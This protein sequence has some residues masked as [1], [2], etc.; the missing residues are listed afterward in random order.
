M[1]GPFSD[2]LIGGQLLAVIYVNAVAEISL[3]PLSRT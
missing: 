2:R 1:F 3:E